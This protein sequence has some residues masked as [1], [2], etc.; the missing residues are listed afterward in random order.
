MGLGSPTGTS[1]VAGTSAPDEAYRATPHPVLLRRMAHRAAD[2]GNGRQAAAMEQRPA[3]HTRSMRALAY[4]GVGTS[5][6]LPRYVE[7]SV[8]RGGRWPGGSS[9]S[10]ASRVFRGMVRSSKYCATTARASAAHPMSRWR[11]R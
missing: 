3:A 10:R 7:R 5:P 11:R 4:M 1:R 8:A 6:A 9:S 2:I